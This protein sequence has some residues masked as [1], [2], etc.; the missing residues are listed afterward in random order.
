MSAERW[1]NTS[2]VV[3][4]CQLSAVEC[5]MNPGSVLGRLMVAEYWQ[6]ASQI[7]AE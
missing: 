7:L 2:R 4:E 1:L 5:R 6:N 3:T